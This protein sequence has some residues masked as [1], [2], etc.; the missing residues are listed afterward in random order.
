MVFGPNL[1][2][3]HGRFWLAGTFGIGVFGIDSAPRL[4]WGIAF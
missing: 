1:A 2:L 4:N 3:T